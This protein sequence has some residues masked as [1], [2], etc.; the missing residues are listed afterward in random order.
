MLKMTDSL[1]LL[2]MYV[3]DSIITGCSTSM[4]AAIKGILHDRFLMTDIVLLHFFL[5]LNINQDASGIKLSHAKYSRYLL[6]IFHMTYYK[7]V[8]NPF[9]SGVRL[10]DGRDTPL[11]DNTLYRQ[12]VGSL[13][14]LTQSRPYLSYVVGVVSKF[15]QESHE[16]QSVSFDMYRAPSP[17]GFIMQQTLH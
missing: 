16:L 3:D 6:E 11:V 17:L 5:G 15:M 1:R 4:I 7:S 9:L 12:L 14:Y 13:L 8:S 10:E 2:V